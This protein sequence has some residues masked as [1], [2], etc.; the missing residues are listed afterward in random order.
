MWDGLDLIYVPQHD[1]GLAYVAC[2]MPYI[3][4]TLH[5]LTYVPCGMS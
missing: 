4:A 2:P 5:G 1:L 3:D